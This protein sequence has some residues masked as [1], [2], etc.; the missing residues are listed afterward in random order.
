MTVKYLI[1]NLGARSKERYRL[2]SDESAQISFSVIAVVILLASTASGLYIANRE[3]DRLSDERRAEMIRSMDAAISEVT[4]ELGL[5]ASTTANKLLSGWD[6]Y[7]VND[8]L[9]SEEYSCMVETYVVD[10]FPRDRGAFNVEVHNWSGSLFFAEKRTLDLLS[11]DDG[12][13]TEVTIDGQSMEYDALPAPSD[14][15]IGERTV[16]PYYVALGTFSVSIQTDDCTLARDECFEKPLLSALP[17]LESKLRAFEQ[18]SSGEY[19]DIGKMVTYM[20]TAL[21]QFR[22]LDGF[23]VPLYSNGSAT[24]MILT[25][26]DVYR[27]VAVAL[28]LEQARLFRSIDGAFSSEVVDA[29]GGSMLGL[30]ALLSCSGCSLDPAEL[31]LW[32]LGLRELQL[33]P[34]IVMAQAIAGIA[35][36]LVIKY[37]DYFGFLGL[38]NV[39][40][41]VLESISNTIDDV[42]EFLTGEDD[43]ADSVRSW[44]ERSLAIVDYSPLLYSETFSCDCDFFVIVP[45]RV[46]YV[47][48]VSGN[49]YPVW[50]GGILADADV[51]EY[52]LLESDLW[53]EFYPVFKECQGEIKDLMYDCV[54][55]LAFDLASASSMEISGCSVDPMD[56]EDMFSLMADH[57]GDVTVCTDP[58]AI[59]IAASSLPFYSTQYKLVDRFIDFIGDHE[60]SIFP[61]DLRTEMCSNIA[62]VVL[63]SARYAYIPDLG[64]SVRQQLQEIVEH[65]VRYDDEW[66]VSASASGSYDSLCSLYV[67]CFGSA[68]DRSIEQADDGFAGPLVDTFASLLAYGAGTIPG[69]ATLLETQVECV[70]N[71]TLAQSR[72]SSYKRSVYVDLFTP[73]EFW[74][75]EREAA[76]GI[77]SVL[78]ESLSIVVQGGLPPLTEVPYDPSIGY[79]SIEQLFPTDDILVQ[80]KRPWD[81]DRAG[82]DYPNTH[83]TSLSNASATPYSTQWLV[84]AKGLVEIEL[85]SESCSLL[86]LICGE[87][88][89]RMQILVDICVPVMVQSSWPLD[90]VDYNPT[91]TALTDAINAARKFYEILWSTIEPLVGWIKDGMERLFTFFQDAFETLAGY[92]TRVLALVAKATQSMVELLQEYIQKFADSALA[93]AVKLF[94]DLVGTVEL[95]I[96][97]YG[98]TIIVRTNLPDLLYKKSQDLV[99][100][101]VC[102]DRF[103][104]G[105]SFGFR[106][107]RLSDGRFDVV[108]NGTL[109]L[110]HVTVEVVVDPLM[111]ILRRFVEVHCRAETWAMDLVIPEAEPYEIAEV[112]T[113]DFPGAGLF[114]SNIPIPVLGMSASIEAG[115]RL[116][117]SPPF[118]TDVVVNE[119]E[120]NP[121]G[122]DSGRE[123]VELYNPLAESRCVDGWVIETAHGMSTELPIY[124]TIPAN[125]LKVFTFP[126]TSIDNGYSGDPFNDGDSLILRDSEGKIVDVTPTL[127]DSAN[128]ARTHQ[129]SWDG[130]PKWQLRD[131]TK[132][133]SNGAS[134]LLS[135]SDFI[136]KALFKAFKE[137][138]EETKLSEVSASLD[139]V[140]LLGKRILSHFIENLLSIVNEVIHEVIIY[141]EV[142]L[143][144]ASGSAGFGFRTSFVVTGDAIVDVLRWLIHTFATFVVNLGRASN[145]IAYPQFPSSFL[146]GLY[147]RFELLFEIGTP[148]MLKVL[149]VASALEN[150]LTM[151]VSI[152]PNIPALGRLVGRSWGNWAVEFGAYLEGVPREYVSGFLV[153]DTG[154]LVDLWLVKGRAYGV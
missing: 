43:S 142:T 81:Y 68:F 48:D 118:P 145:P 127:S 125:G 83:M 100:I 28:L 103:G 19:S 34:A 47:E 50:V 44:M 75:G 110:K 36:M 108:V 99:R 8:T 121:Q 91:N 97:M 84:S 52:N 128:D 136:A 153:K 105:I 3:I 12:K 63:D 126:Q 94:I 151:V 31:F 55:R 11:A 116:K 41:E 14:D 58:E 107:A 20:L 86:S 65:D 130:G 16:N 106:I 87:E 38:F 152:A 85:S 53:A 119:F 64:V 2:M 25:E 7:P 129:R 18:A 23:G 17:F 42:M 150:R 46:Y 101:I 134:V 89:S 24:D 70:A 29:C 117:Y 26:H 147:I 148:K 149:G 60:S 69:I 112:S 37:L 33:D 123:W 139:F 135:T 120:A 72:I 35:D 77:S 6:E 21:S 132:G 96:T 51:P 93:K 5:F 57:A 32:F 61:E 1:A 56:G 102:T 40:D 82:Q 79:S 140:T 10:S 73:F 114:L 144:D 66:G 13:A 92:A 59:M 74:D 90:G 113:S 141:I 22:V 111:I 27:A 115:L 137:A 15:S 104:P 78:N 95:R 76:D 109:S 133:D 62:S 154:D 54:Q 124:G 30:L 49:L 9:I 122:D 131:G 39:A 4:I 138:F 45:E 71:A 143:S 67:E 88:S 98:F 80:V 146:S